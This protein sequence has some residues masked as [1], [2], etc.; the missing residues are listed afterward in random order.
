MTTCFNQKLR[1]DCFVLITVS[2]KK[3]LR[4]G[5]K[6]ISDPWWCKK[7]WILVRVSQKHWE[8]RI[9][10]MFI[11]VRVSIHLLIQSSAKHGTPKK[12]STE[13][14]EG[15]DNQ[16]KVLLCT[17]CS[18]ASFH[19]GFLIFQPLQLSGVSQSV[20]IQTK[21]NIELSGSQYIYIYRNTTGIPSKEYHHRNT[22]RKSH[23][24]FVDFLC[25]SFGSGSS[26]RVEDSFGSDSSTTNPCHQADDVRP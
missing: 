13:W 24:K 15:A 2:I 4:Q 18:K 12:E 5:A 19:E 21:K 17:V 22:H 6:E 23:P 1:W 7:K 20:K 25:H 16:Q 9:Y 10:R 3:L 14:S 11:T 26:K 8:Q